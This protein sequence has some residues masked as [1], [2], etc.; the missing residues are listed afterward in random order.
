MPRFRPTALGDLAARLGREVEGDATRVVRGVASLDDAG[1]DDLVFVRGPRFADAFARCR[2]GAVIA[3]PSVATGGRPTLRSPHPDWDFARAVALLV[4]PE[5]PPAG[6]HPSAVV[7]PDAQVDASASIGPFAYVGAR[8]RVGARSVLHANVV[9]YADVAIGADCELHAGCVLREETQL[10]D[11][12]I[13]QPGAV[14]GGDGFGYAFDP[15]GR[16]EKMPQIGHVV[17]DDDVEIGALAAVDRATL[18]VTRIGRGAKID[19]LCVVAHNCDVGEDVL[20]VA[21]SGLAGCTVVERGAILMAQTGTPGHLRIGER[22]FLGG[23]TGVHKDVPPGARLFGAPAMP[24]RAWHRTMA[25]LAR[26]PDAAAARAR[27]RAPRRRPPAARRGR[28]VKRERARQRSPRAPVRPRTPARSERCCA[29]CG[30][31]RAPARGARRR[32]RAA[33]RRGATRARPARPALRAAP[34]AA[35]GT[36]R[37]AWP[38]S[39]RSASGRSRV[40]SSRRRWSCPQRVALPG[41]DDSKRLAR[42]ARERL[43]AAIRA[44]A[45]AIAVGEVWPDEIDRLNIYRAGLEAMRRAV[46]ALAIAPDHVL[47]DARTIPAHRGA[48][49]GARRRRRPRR[50]DRRRLDRREGAPRRDH[51]CASTRAYPGYGFAR[52]MGYATRA[53]PA[54][55]A[56]ASVRRRCT[57]AR[58]LPCAQLALL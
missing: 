11:R 15:E 53:A 18:G 26:L 33:P 42:A 58:S 43:D 5:R 2:A 39:T 46:A 6:V 34:P 24:E 13:L 48:A 27:A 12:V 32:A 47:V 36:A 23:R 55:A 20:I 28:G 51:A 17:I 38:A 4:V 21:Q 1:P 16:P 45:L 7:A 29:C 8:T 52:H 35:C 31:I 41:L 44:Q 25:A 10:G 30:T 49:D 19:D 54:R 22:A 37:R 57:A 9:L 14:I 40:R 3:P 56:R 50:L